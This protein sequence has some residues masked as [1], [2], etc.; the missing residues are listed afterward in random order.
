ML[1]IWNCTKPI[2]D[3]QRQKE[4]LR[5][6]D[7]S[8][9]AS[10]C[11][12]FAPVS[13][14]IFTVWASQCEENMGCPEGCGSPVEKCWPNRQAR[15]IPLA[16]GHPIGASSIPVGTRSLLAK[17]SVLYLCFRWRGKG[18]DGIVSAAW[19]SGRQ[20]LFRGSRAGGFCGTILANRRNC[21]SQ[22]ELDCA[23]LRLTGEGSKGI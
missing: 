19:Q 2:S 17:S 8:A 23:N 1:I 12:F 5:F 11:F 13:N 6:R 10:F 16:P 18:D 9:D 22:A 20:T 3:C 14:C 21:S 7:H 4:D 15:R